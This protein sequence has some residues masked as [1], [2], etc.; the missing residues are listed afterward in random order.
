MRRPIAF[1]ATLLAAAASGIV[2]ASYAA[3]ADT[4]TPLPISGFAAMLV[5]EA[6]SRV[7]FAPG[8]GGSAVVVT[9]LSGANP[10]SLTVPA[11]PTGLAADG[12]TIWVASPGDGS[13]S[14]VDASTLTVTTPYTGL[15]CPRYL[16]F[17]AARLWYS[18]GCAS[19]SATVG[20]IDPAT[21]TVTPGAVS[22]TWTDPPYLSAAGGVLAVG[23][24]GA[25]PAP[26]S[27]YTVSS[28][29][30]VSRSAVSDA[31]VCSE[32]ASLTVTP[33]GAD[34]VVACGSPDH[35][36]MLSSSDLTAP[37]ESTYGGG[38]GVPAGVAMTSDGGF[39]AA[40]FTQTSSNNVDVY[41]VGAGTAPRAQYS[42]NP[43]GV[44]VLPRDG[45]RYGSSSGNLYAVIPTNAAQTA[46]ALEVLH[47]TTSYGATVTVTAP[48]TAPRAQPLTVKGQLASTVAPISGAQ[49]LHVTRTDL[50][51]TATLPDVTAADGTGAFSFADVPRVGG[52]V[53]YDVTWPGDSAHRE[54]S[55]RATVQVSRVATTIAI[56][57]NAS[58]YR[59]HA[60]AYVTAH[61]GPTY[62]SRRVAIYAT[63]Y[64]G[65][66]TL[67]RSTNVNAHGYLFASYVVSRRTTF[68]AVFA[69][70]YRHA[71]AS[72][73][74]T[75][76][77][78][79]HLAEQLQG[80]YATSHGFRLYHRSQNPI[81]GAQLFPTQWGV[82]LYFRAQRYYTG[83]WHTV[84]LSHCYKTDPAGEQA[85]ALYPEHIVGQPYR[86]RAE[87]HG[88]KVALADVGRW[89]LLKFT[90]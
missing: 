36:S 89:V 79:A 18:H 30:A 17:A 28:G 10:T 35:L 85:A 60:R 37:A 34:V 26:L 70:D 53:T 69:G 78:R 56:A 80:Y 31:N 1:V 54:S 76:A 44:G 52:P 6:H 32:L 62:N 16:A 4:S 29:S 40:G 84:A 50:S 63:P 21:G 22:G 3:A 83:A 55:G 19:G 71:P 72:A 23:Q 42:L 20:S 5:D 64:R 67:L 41:P 2:T 66:R 47:G 57:T 12:T 43:S 75:V 77:V 39:V 81:L 82:C 38:N 7:F 48:G 90:R 65:K 27:T 8:A 87:W 25:S 58:R 13:I 24:L 51:G 49:T 74:R 15:D 61:L 59:Y 33:S 68:T 14:A 88:N 46:F 11:G 45:L 73:S 9:D 86:L